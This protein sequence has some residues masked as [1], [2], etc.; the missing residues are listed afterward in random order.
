MGIGGLGAG[1]LGAYCC[2]KHDTASQEK[3]EA[4][5]FIEKKLEEKK[6][7]SNAIGAALM[8]KMKKE[9]DEQ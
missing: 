6:K 9:A 4:I 7:Q 2:N 5:E 1:F 3:E 8:D